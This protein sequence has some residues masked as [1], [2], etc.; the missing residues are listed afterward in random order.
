[1][2]RIL[3]SWVS[4]HACM[5]VERRQDVYGTRTS[6]QVVRSCDN[7]QRATGIANARETMIVSRFARCHLPRVPN[8]PFTPQATPLHSLPRP[9]PYPLLYFHSS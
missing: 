7:I 9:I 4:A 6:R 8:P 2:G 5:H 1:M 3:L